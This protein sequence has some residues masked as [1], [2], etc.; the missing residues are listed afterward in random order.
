[1]ITRPQFS[2]TLCFATLAVIAFF[3]RT[4]S[5]LYAAETSDPVLKL[6]LEKGIISQEELDRARAEAAAI[7]RTNATTLSE[8]QFAAASASKWRISDGLKSVELFGDLRMRYEEREAM[9]SEDGSIELGRARIAIRLGLR[10]EV[11]DGFYYGLRLDTGSN[12]RSPWV[13]LGTSSSAVP[14]Q[15]PFGKSTFNVNIGQ[16]YLGWH[17][18]DW[19]DLTVGKMPN[20]LYTRPMVWDSDLNP[21]G[22]AEHL[23]YTIGFADFFANFGQY[24]YQDTN[25]TEASPGYFGLGNLYPSPNGSSSSLPLLLAW[26]AGVN[27]RFTTNISF[28][29]APAVYMYEG[30]GVN[31]TTTATLN[32]PDFYGTFVGEGAT[33]GVSGIP[34]AGWSGYPGGFFAGF[35]A[36]QTGVNDLL[37]LE[38]PWELN[39]KVRALDVS[40]FGDYAQNLEGRQRAHAAYNASRSSNLPF[41]IGG[42]RP[43]ASVQPNEDKAY[44]F[45]IAVGNARSI[46]L[47]SGATMRRHGWEL[48]AYWQHVEQYALDPNLLD[49]DF[50][51]GRG[52]MEGVHAALAY[53][54]SQNV[55]GTVRYGYATRINPSLGTGGANQDIPQMN[56]IEKFSLLQFDLGLKF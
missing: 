42:V 36:N 34:A 45:G 17:K 10:G 35:N 39:F 50:F 7:A 33:N 44:L 6:L 22:L 25:P 27:V 37:I 54:F 12:P 49:S 38:F 1:M 28:K 29:I 18:Y 13:T 3:L 9:D 5:F 16:V 43:I 40:L 8:A 23:K 31:S 11:L 4:H 41:Q 2:R 32:S 24:I 46:G 52:N 26:Q 53:G 51:E 14:Y 47:A 48:R 19:L 30:V 56:P 20:P 21:E 55:I 15:G